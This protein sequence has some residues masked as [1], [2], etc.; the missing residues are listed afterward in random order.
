MV[1]I[2]EVLPIIGMLLLGFFCRK[3]NYISREG[4]NDIK[5]LV[6]KIFLPV[7]IFNALATAE[8]SGKTIVS[9]LI[10]LVMLVVSFGLAHLMRPLNKGP[11]EKY[12]PYMITV[13]EGGMVAYPLFMNLCGSENMFEIA[14]ID[15]AGLIFGFGVYMGMLEQMESGEKTDLISLYKS[16]LK[17]PTFD[18]AVLG[19]IAGV[20]GVIK[21]L[22]FSD[23]GVVYQTLESMLTVAMTPMILI[24]VGYD[25]IFE[26]TTIRQSIKTIV[27][28]MV[29]QAMLIVLVIWAFRHFVGENIIRDIAVICYMSSPATFSLQSF[30]KRQESAKYVATTCSLYCIVS[31]AVYI[32]LSIII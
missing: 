26:K 11:Y 14:I 4:I 25:L 1:V 23:A 15:I 20:S 3:H 27:L 7:A 24:V 10:M 12:T 5:F 22:L 6:T 19:V 21:L 28:R 8:Y 2:S 16:A 32:V 13:Y 31:I 9:I 17:N 30:I 29:Y 18:A